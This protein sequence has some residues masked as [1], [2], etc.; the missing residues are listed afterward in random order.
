MYEFEKQK[1]LTIDKWSRDSR[2]RK[3]YKLASLEKLFNL[4][5]LYTKELQNK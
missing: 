4:I 5:E 2:E 3:L 1:F